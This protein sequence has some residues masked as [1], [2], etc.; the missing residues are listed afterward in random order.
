VALAVDAFSVD[1]ELEVGGRII[2]DGGSCAVAAGDPVKLEAG[3]GGK[4]VLRAAGGSTALAPVASVLPDAGSPFRL[5]G[6][7]YGG[8][9]DIFHDGAALIVL[10]RIGLEE[11]LTGVVGWEIGFLPEEKIEALK[12]QAVAA[13]TY[14]LH[15]V[16]VSEEI[17]D[18]EASVSDQV[19]RGLEKTTPAV[20][21]A[22]EETAGVVA[23]YRG[24]LLRTYYSSTCGG[25]TV[26][27]EEVWFDRDPA[28][29]L[30]GVP[31]G[32][33][34]RFDEERA[35][36]AA[37]PRF[38]WTEEWAGEARIASI[39]VALAEEAG[40]PVEE[41]GE[42]RDIRIVKRGRSGRAYTTRFT[43]DGGD[44]DIGGDRVRWVL[45]RQENGGILG[46]AWF[47]LDVERSGGLVRRVT[48]RGRGFGHGIGMCQWG[49]MGMAEAGY[50]FAQILKHYYPGARL[51]QLDPRMLA[52]SGR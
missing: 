25:R 29:Y 14:A 20:N 39:V 45:R 21:R 27:L 50:N 13:R 19:Y 24:E 33:G 26:G 8:T 5:D 35:W 11:Y 18:V 22:I 28:P 41:L 17:W 2:W 38:R 32:P 49:A 37:S 6:T 34:R 12:S 47:D 42:L 30:E 40:R 3:A 31:D 10:N 1:L 44:V 52:K 23:T 51:G 43:T 9:L 48:A 4:I 7:R 16:Q 36:C 46:S 15:R